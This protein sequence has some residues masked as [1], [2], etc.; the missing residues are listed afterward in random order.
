MKT[1]FIIMAAFTGLLLV[2]MGSQDYEG[3]KHRVTQDQ[4]QQFESRYP[5]GF[6]TTPG[7]KSRNLPEGC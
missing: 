3:G 7:L 6:P 5:C 1:I 2:F 4:I